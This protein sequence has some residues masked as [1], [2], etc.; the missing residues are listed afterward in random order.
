MQPERSP[1]F[2]NDREFALAVTG[3]VY[4]TVDML[5]GGEEQTPAEALARI[6]RLILGAAAQRPEDAR[7]ILDKA[8]SA[9]G[10]FSFL[11]EDLAKEP[12]H[13]QG[14]VG[15]GKLAGEGRKMA[16]LFALLQLASKGKVHVTYQ[17]TDTDGRPGVDTAAFQELLYQ[18]F[19][20]L[21]LSRALADENIGLVP[22]EDQT[23]QGLVRALNQSASDSRYQNIPQGVLSESIEF[24]NRFGYHRSVARVYRGRI[25]DEAAVVLT[26]MLLREKA[27]ESASVVSVWNLEQEMNRFGGVQELV[28]HVSRMIQ[29]L[30]LIE[31][32]A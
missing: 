13:L 8:K 17:V 3:G 29:S 16:D 32:A 11:L 2:E 18:A 20:R 6:V 5:A 12:I 27:V 28:A 26:A 22:L 25:N 21:Q 15:D 24:L 31:A 30:Q 1:S 7:G 19:E 14:I 10:G 23:E 4:P 9:L